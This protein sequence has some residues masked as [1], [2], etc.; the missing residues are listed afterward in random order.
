MVGD[1]GGPGRSA[2]ELRAAYDTGARLWAEGPEPVYASLA[3][4]LLAR[5]L[6]L[7]VAGG[8]GLDLGAGAG[9][10]DARDSSRVSADCSAVWPVLA[11]SSTSQA[12][13]VGQ[14]QINRLM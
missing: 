3:R 14:S 4:A 12:G 9:G 10:G 7:G 8:R 2:A 6:P 1:A 5:V 13:S 11:A